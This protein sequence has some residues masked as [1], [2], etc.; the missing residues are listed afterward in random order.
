MIIH[1]EMQRQNFTITTDSQPPLTV[2]EVSAD[3]HVSSCSR[4][5]LV[6]AVQY[7]L[8]CDGVE[9]LFCKTKVY[10]VDYVFAAG[11]PPSN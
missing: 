7:V 3:A 6:L 2:A 5:V 1:K 4:Q 11:R 9:I 10:D 8:M